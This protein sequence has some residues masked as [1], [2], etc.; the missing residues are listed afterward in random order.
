[1]SSDN[2]NWIIWTFF[3][4]EHWIARVDSE[5]VLYFNILR[6]GTNKLVCPN[7]ISVLPITFPPP[8]SLGTLWSPT[9]TLPDPR[10]LC[11]GKVGWLLTEIS[12]Y[13]LCHSHNL[14][15]SIQEPVQEH[16]TLANLWGP[17]PQELVCY[18]T[19]ADF[20]FV[21]ERLSSTRPLEP[22]INSPGLKPVRRVSGMVWTALV[23]TEF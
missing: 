11:K 21:F 15:H 13:A 8:G 14:Q 1:M 4:S 23:S 3:V 17:L 9:G 22:Y 12:I 19:A 5:G 6:A 7:W 16:W 2:E 18:Q 10:L 20:A